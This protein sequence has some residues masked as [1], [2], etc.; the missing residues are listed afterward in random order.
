MICPDCDGS[1][2]VEVEYAVGG[3]TRNRWVEIRTRVIECP[4]CAGWGADV[5]HVVKA[6]TRGHWD[7]VEDDGGD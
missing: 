4:T 7:E 6:V 5:D 1:G 2:E 3:Y